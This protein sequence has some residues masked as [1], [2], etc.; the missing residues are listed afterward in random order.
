MSKTGNWV[1]EM[2]EDAYDMTLAEFIKKHGE[3]QS[4]LWHQTQ[5]EAEEG[6]LIDE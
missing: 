6:V 1:L 4:S 3:S 5:E 2:Q